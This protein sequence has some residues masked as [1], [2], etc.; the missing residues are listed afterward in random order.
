MPIKVILNDIKDFYK[1]CGVSVKEPSFETQKPQRQVELM[2][3]KH[4][5]KYALNM[6][7]SPKNLFLEDSHGLIYPLIFNCYIC[8]MSVLTPA[9]Y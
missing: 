7:K 1:K 5:I 2:H 3:C 4:C 9:F 8:E 6:C